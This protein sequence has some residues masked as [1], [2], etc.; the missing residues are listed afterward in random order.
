MYSEGG[1]CSFYSDISESAAFPVYTAYTRVQ[2]A[3]MYMANPSGHA[4][5]DLLGVVA[6]NVGSWSR[7][8]FV[9]VIT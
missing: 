6:E 9:S 1:G 8:S 3:D 2:Q 7:I 4:L 5:Q